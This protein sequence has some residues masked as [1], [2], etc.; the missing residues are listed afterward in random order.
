MKKSLIVLIVILAIVFIIGGIFVSA[1]NDMITMAEEVEAQWAVVETRL[2]RRFDLIPNLVASVEGIMSQ[3]KE[4]F[5]SI[6]DARARLAGATTLE[7]RVEASNQ[8]ESALGRLLVVMENYPELKSAESVNRLMDELAG[9][10]NRISVERDRY[11]ETVR[12]FNSSIKRFP[13]NIIAG[14]M[15]FEPKVY[16][17]AE[18]GAERA[19]KV[20]FNK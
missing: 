13:R 20:E 1:Y 6:A 2:Q 8:L 18:A 4:V 3:E 17:E 16:F 19:P 12:K 11:N 9:T 14:M 7:E 5:S 15:G 10:E